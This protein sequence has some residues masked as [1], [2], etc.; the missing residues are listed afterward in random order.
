[1]VSSWMI[2]T[3]GR[4]VG[5]NLLFL[6]VLILMV[7]LDLSIAP[8]CVSPLVNAFISAGVQRHTHKL[9]NFFHYY[10]YPSS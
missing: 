5:R 4:Y 8:F 9:L 3:R 6:H 7:I 10:I 1:M 2:C